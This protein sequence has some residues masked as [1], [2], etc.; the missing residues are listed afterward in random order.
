MADHSASNDAHNDE[1]DAVSGAHTAIHRH[2]TGRAAIEAATNRARN[3]TIVIGADQSQGVLVL[4]ID[5]QADICSGA[6]ELR[7]QLMLVVE[8]LDG[9]DPMRTLPGKPTS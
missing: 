8:A 1:S 5:V 7:E 2:R 6:A 3:T 4:D 9:Y